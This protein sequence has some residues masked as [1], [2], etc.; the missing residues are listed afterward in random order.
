MANQDEAMAGPDEN[1]I[2]FRHFTQFVTH[3]LPQLLQQNQATQL[4]LNQILQSNRNEN[5]LGAP[6]SR[7]SQE[8]WNHCQKLSLNFYTISSPTQRL[9]TGSIGTKIFSQQMPVT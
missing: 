2:F 8:S 6:P 3:Q 5:F 4:Q 1:A 9:R 7:T